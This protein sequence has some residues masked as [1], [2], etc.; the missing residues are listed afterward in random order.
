MPARLR[1]RISAGAALVTGLGALGVAAAMPAQAATTV[2]Y[3]CTVEVD[4]HTI[5]TE[6]QATIDTNAPD[7]VGPG[8]T[9]TVDRVTADVTIP[10]PGLTAEDADSGSVSLVVPVEAPVRSGADV[11]GTVGTTLTLESAQV[12]DGQVRA[13][14]ASTDTHSVV[15]PVEAAGATVEVFV[16]PTLEG[17]LTVPGDEGP[18]VA[19]SCST[20]D[21]DNVIDAVV[22][23]SPEMDEGPD[24]A[25]DTAENHAPGGDG[26]AAPTAPEVPA[27][28]QTDGLTP[29]ATGNGDHTAALAL[30]GLA[31]AGAGAGTVL[32]ARRRAAQH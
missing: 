12:S 31:L 18:N 32:V 13:T 7:T 6:V 15:V 16:P 21:T 23:T 9:L 22:V 27:V 29:A 25:E 19:V 10:V 24:D 4:G 11:R 26:T 17:T 2:T 3:T 1:T 30:G 14:L 20:T 8:E 28:V 5:P